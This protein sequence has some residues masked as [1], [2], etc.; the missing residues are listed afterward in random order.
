M[1]RDANIIKHCRSAIDELLQEYVQQPYFNMREEDFRSSL[2]QKL[3]DRVEETV[4]VKLVWDKNGKSLPLPENGRDKHTTSRIHSEVRFG[5]TSKSPKFDI[6]ILKAHP[7]SFYVR[8]SETDVLSKLD[9]NDV[10]VVIEVK[11][12]PSNRQHNEFRRDIEK[13]KQLTRTRLDSNS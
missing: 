10:E 2:L 7:V 13:L 5:K 1:S 12:A 6:V 3:R 11:A 4:E 8:Q 9:I